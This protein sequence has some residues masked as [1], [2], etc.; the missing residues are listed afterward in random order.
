MS[1]IG[2]RYLHVPGAVQQGLVL[3]CGSFVINGS[4]PDVT[5]FLG[6]MLGCTVTRAAAGRY[7]FVLLN[8][9]YE[10]LYGSANVSAF[11]GNTE[12]IYGQCDTSAASTTGTITVHTK[13]AGTDT[14][15]ASTEVVQVLLVCRKTDRK[16]TA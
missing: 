16:N 7:T 12:D 8:L 14:D 11:T 10:V 13:T 6:D 2:D 9:P 4:T 3:W 5:K 1:T 15:P